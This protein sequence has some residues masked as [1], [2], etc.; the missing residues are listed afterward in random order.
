MRSKLAGCCCTGSQLANLYALPSTCTTTSC[1]SGP[2]PTPGPHLRISPLV[3]PLPL[4]LPLPL[5]S[6]TIDFANTAAKLR[7]DGA[8]DVT[9][10]W[11]PIASAT[12]YK[13]LYCA[14]S[15]RFT[16]NSVIFLRS[17]NQPDTSTFTNDSGLITGTKVTINIPAMQH[18]KFLVYCYNGAPTDL[19]TDPPIT[20]VIVTAGL[21]NV[22]ELWPTLT[23][24][25]SGS[26]PTCT[27][28]YTRETIAAADVKGVV[29]LESKAF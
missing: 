5:P 6:P 13:V 12:S 16:S 19:R 11:F 28:L 15:N 4:P 9:L 2:T 8:I 20:Q 14:T 21:Q 23:I 18:S 7:F 26:P 24:T 27:N 22:I 25:S 3:V 17:D 29:P 10:A 1:D